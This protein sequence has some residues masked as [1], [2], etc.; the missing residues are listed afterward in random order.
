MCSKPPAI[1]R[2][3]QAISGRPPAISRR[4]PAM[5]GR[6]PAISR[7]SPAISGR[8]PA[9]SRRPPA[10]SGRPPAI[11]RR[12]PAIS[13]RP[14]AISKRPPMI[15][16]ITLKERRSWCSKS[17]APTSGKSSIHG[18]LRLIHQRITTPHAALSTR[19]PQSGFSARKYTRNGTH[20]DPCCGSMANLARGRAFSVLQ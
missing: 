9:I 17:L 8:P 18:S 5:S 20:R 14:P 7:R 16:R 15:S 3:P 13:G 19:K 2:R 11:S 1:S 10:M 12:S 6:P 4:P